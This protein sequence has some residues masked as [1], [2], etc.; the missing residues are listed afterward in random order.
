MINFFLIIAIPAKV[1]MKFL[2]STQSFLLVNCDLERRSYKSFTIIKK[3][4][5]EVN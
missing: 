4:F 2:L 3:Y 1:S 5:A